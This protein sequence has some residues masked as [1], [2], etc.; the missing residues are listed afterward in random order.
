MLLLCTC[1]G[2]YYIVQLF[3]LIATSPV[4]LVYDARPV[5]CSEIPFPAV[6][7]S[8]RHNFKNTTV[9][10]IYKYVKKLFPFV[11]MS[12]LKL[13]YKTTHS[14]NLDAQYYGTDQTMGGVT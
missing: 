3:L 5:H 11:S 10:D 4:L 12:M 6:T 13:I 8:K 1:I 9:E 2:L 7:W 14:L